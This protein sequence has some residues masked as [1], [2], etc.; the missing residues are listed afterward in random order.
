MIGKVIPQMVVNR[1]GRRVALDIQCVSS[2]SITTIFG[3]AANC[4]MLFETSIAPLSDSGKDR[5]RISGV[6]ATGF[7]RKIGRFSTSRRLA[8]T[9]S[10]RLES[11]RHSIMLP[12]V[13]RIEARSKNAFEHIE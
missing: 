4:W 12:F 9:R 8:R 3:P 11:P 5:G 2:V 6:L 7:T 1:A 10:D 13:A